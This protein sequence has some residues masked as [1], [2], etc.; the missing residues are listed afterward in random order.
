MGFDVEPQLPAIH[1]NTA[2]ISP[3]AS[4]AAHPPTAEELDFVARQKARLAGE[5]AY[6]RVHAEK[7]QT[8]AYA[9]NDSPLALAAWI[10]EK[11]HGWTNPDDPDLEAIDLDALLANICAYWF[12]GP[13][14]MHWL[15]QTLRD[16]SGYRLPGGR[17]V[18]T[19]TGFCLFPLDIAVPPPRAWLERSFNVT[20]LHYAA[21][22]G[23][24][25]GLENPAL[26]TADIQRFF[27][28][29]R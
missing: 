24:F 22:G 7:P 29:F 11:F 26:L 14:P 6:Q 13:R 19:P 9:L 25:P 27:R 21:Q 8:L 3:E 16:G 5:D 12:A 28:S 2:V 10:T 15:Y 17:R 18:E 23:H 20:H 4:L 1:L